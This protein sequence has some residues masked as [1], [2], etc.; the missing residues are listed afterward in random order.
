MSTA[1][2]PREKSRAGRKILAGRRRRGGARRV[3][4]PPARHRRPDRRRPG[5]RGRVR[6]CGCVSGGVRYS[7]GGWIAARRRRRYQGWAGRRDV[8]RAARSAHALTRRLAPGAS[9][10]VLGT[11]GRARAACRRMPGELRPLPRPARLRED[12][13]AGLP[14]RRRPRR[15]VRHVHQDRAAPRHAPVP[16]VA[17]RPDLDPEP[18][19][20]RQHP[21]HPGLVPAGR[22]RVPRDRD[23]PR[24]RP[25]R[26]IPPRQDRQGLLAR[27]PRRGTAPVHAAR[28]RDR[29]RD[30][31]A[32]PG[33][34]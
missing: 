26:R 7:S 8:A 34:G 22:L 5:R 1:A 32:R 23:P 18:R 11:R 16:D 2:K 27:G 24:R 10:L 3:R 14:R 33:P 13:R 21:H 12:R 4:H 19:R 30:R 28:R 9:L 25:D 20:V 17:G 15:P 6:R 29:R 31:C